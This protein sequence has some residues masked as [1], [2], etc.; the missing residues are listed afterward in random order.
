[1]VRGDVSVA[2]Q[3]FRRDCASSLIILG[4]ALEHILEALK[5]STPL[6]V[7]NSKGSYVLA[8]REDEVAS[9]VAEG[10]TNRQIAHKLGVA[11]H[12]VSNYLFRIYDKL[13]ISSR[14]ELV[15]Y[16]LKQGLKQGRS[17]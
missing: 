13:G 11:E 10:M 4:W 2:F 5:T 8:P 7:I 15:L 1:M 9:L 16:V 17:A 14:V 3:V 6:R 12:T